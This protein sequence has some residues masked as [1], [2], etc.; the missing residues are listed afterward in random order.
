MFSLDETLISASAA[1]HCGGN[2]CATQLGELVSFYNA[3]SGVR[4]GSF[5]RESLLEEYDYEPS[6]RNG[7]RK[8]GVSP[9][10]VLI[11]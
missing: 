10:R 3:V 5:R 11:G 4:E 6:Y 1:P 2:Q 8:S 7:D 9:L